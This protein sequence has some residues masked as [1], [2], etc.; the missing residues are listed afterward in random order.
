MGETIDP[1]DTSYCTDENLTPVQKAILAYDREH[2]TE[3]AMAH[4]ACKHCS[5]WAE[6]DYVW[7]LEDADHA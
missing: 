2:G 7:D 4:Y 6:A 3:Y 1:T 5:A